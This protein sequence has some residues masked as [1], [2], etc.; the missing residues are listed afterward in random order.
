MYILFGSNSLLV[1]VPSAVISHC[2]ANAP[3]AKHV[4]CTARYQQQ[5][6]Q[7]GR[8]MS[9]FLQMQNVGM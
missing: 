1:L 8:L 2:V 4:C 5:P 7:A 6:H 3:V 9:L